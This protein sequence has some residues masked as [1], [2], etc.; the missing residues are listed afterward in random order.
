MPAGKWGTSDRIAHITEDD[1]NRHYLY[2]GTTTTTISI[3]LELE[4][5]HPTKDPGGLNKETT[6]TREDTTTNR[7]II[8]EETV[9]GHTDKTMTR[10]VLT[11][12][13]RA[14]TIS[15]RLVTITRIKTWRRKFRISYRVTRASP[16]SNKLRAKC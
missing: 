5:S 16:P 14:K 8:K 3:H 7:G 15:R 1:R 9:K 13:P 4:G 10:I 6:I 12:I 11:T 2:N